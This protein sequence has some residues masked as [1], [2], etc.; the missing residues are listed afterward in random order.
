MVDETKAIFQWLV[1]VFGGIAT[2]IGGFE[3]VKAVRKHIMERRK[4][5]E[6]EQAK[7]IAA[8]VAEA[9]KE[10]L[11]EIKRELRTVSEQQ[12][13]IQSEKINWAYDYFFI[14]RKPLPLYQ[15]NAREK[16]YKQYTG[17]GY[18]EAHQNGV[19]HDFLEK[20]GDCEIVG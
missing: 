18:G 7:R 12:G 11:G 2:I 5:K 14:K 8:A 1:A 17:N 10:E 6:N 16:M 13:T 3:A 9:Q 20:L 15:K 19:P 4:E